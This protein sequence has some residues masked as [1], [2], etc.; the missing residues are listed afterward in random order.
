MT[1]EE[2]SAALFA[3]VVAATGIWVYIL[4]VFI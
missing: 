1:D 3:C 2:L 4:A